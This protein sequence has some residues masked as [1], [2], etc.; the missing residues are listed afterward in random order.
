LAAWTI[1]LLMVQPVTLIGQQADLPDQQPGTV[2]DWHTTAILPRA[3]AHSNEDPTPAVQ[4][5]VDYH[6]AFAGEVVF[7]WGLENWTVVPE[8]DRRPPGTYVDRGTVLNTPMRKHGESFRVTFEAPAYSR[9]DFAFLV[10]QSSDGK[11]VRI[12]QDNGG[13]DFT[14]MLTLVDVEQVTVRPSGRSVHNFWLAG[15]SCILT[16]LIIAWLVALTSTK[17]ASDRSPPLR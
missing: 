13:N 14:R 11:P 3:D 6:D 8:L 4:V 9:V 10:T 2:F 5:D 15:I 7:I 16:A 17:P 1:G 12:L